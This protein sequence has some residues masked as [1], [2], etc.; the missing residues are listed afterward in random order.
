M[1]EFIWID[2]NIEKIAAH[3]LSPEEVEVA[4][5]NGRVV[6]RGKTDPVHGP[7]YVSVGVCPSGRLITIVWRYNVDRDGEEKV[8]VITAFGP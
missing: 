8:F 3:Y 6:R 2:W 4:W 1:A 7:S 5:E